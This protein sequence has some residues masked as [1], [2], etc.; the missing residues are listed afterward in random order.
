MAITI[1]ALAG[2]LVMIGMA[3]EPEVANWLLSGRRRV[4]VSLLGR[5]VVVGLEVVVVVVVGNGGKSSSINSSSS[6][7]ITNSS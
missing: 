1:A 2:V 5:F 6:S 7:S 4:A 3:V